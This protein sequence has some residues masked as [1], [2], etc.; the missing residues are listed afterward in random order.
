MASPEN[1]NELLDIQG[2]PEQEQSSKES[3]DNITSYQKPPTKPSK[4]KEQ[5]KTGTE[6]KAGDKI[7]TTTE[8]K[9]KKTEESIKKLNDHLKRNTCPKSLRYSAR[10]NIPADEEFKK[11]IKTLKQKAER[12]FVEALTRF[13]YCRL[14]KQ[15]TKLNQENSKTRR[16]GHTML[17]S[18]TKTKIDPTKLRAMAT[19]LQK[20]YNE[21]NRI[22][23][24]LNDSTENKNCEKYSC[25]SVKYVTNSTGAPGTDRVGQ[26]YTKTQ[27]ST[28]KRRKRRK[29][30]SNNISSFQ[31]PLGR[32]TLRTCQMRK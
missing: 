31:K 5:R 4:H 22:L 26:S 1:E 15:K 13:H 19:N 23:S 25:E 28:A 29:K 32:S 16:N 17:T 21:V 2:Q 12:G 18:V 30:S 8:A 14:E 11:D 24:Q 20:Q 27:R 10:A 9:I 7:R 3:D 6:R